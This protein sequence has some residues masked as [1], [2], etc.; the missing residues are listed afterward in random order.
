[1]ELPRVEAAVPEALAL[2]LRPQAVEAADW[3]LRCG[4]VLEPA[5]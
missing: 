5:R 2:G 1:M 3:A 4:A